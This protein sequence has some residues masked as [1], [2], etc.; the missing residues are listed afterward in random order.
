[1]YKLRRPRLSVIPNDVTVTEF[2]RTND[3]FPEDVVLEPPIVFILIKKKPDHTISIFLFSFMFDKFSI[4]HIFKFIQPPRQQASASPVSLI[5]HHSASQQVNQ[6]A[7]HTHLQEA[8]SFLYIF[9]YLRMYKYIRK[10]IKICFT[11]LHI[12]KH[13]YIFIY[14]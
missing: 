10:Y 14:I 6:S 12:L 2:S 8:S 3:S 5:A 1:M 9:T 11:Y 4:F 7:I 13:F